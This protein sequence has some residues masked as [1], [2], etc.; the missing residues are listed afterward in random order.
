MTNT[1]RV[2]V[3]AV[4]DA[5]YPN[6]RDAVCWEGT[7]KAGDTLYIPEKWWHFIKSLSVSFSV[8]FWWQ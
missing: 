3:E 4:D 6:F 8:S 2:D 7:L 1:S 5:L